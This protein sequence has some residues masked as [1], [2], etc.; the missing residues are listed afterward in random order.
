MSMKCLFQLPLFCADS[1]GYVQM[2]PDPSCTA[3]K[4]YQSSYLARRDFIIGIHK[5]R[6]TF[7][8]YVAGDIFCFLAIVL[9]RFI[10]TRKDGWTFNGRPTEHPEAPMRVRMTRFFTEN[11]D[12]NSFFGIHKALSL[13]F[14]KIG[15]EIDQPTFIQRYLYYLMPLDP[16]N[17]KKIDFEVKPGADYY[18]FT[19]IFEIIAAVY[20]IFFWGN[21]VSSSAD[22]EAAFANSRFPWKMVAF[23]CLEILIMVVERIIY[24]FRSVLAKSMLQFFTLLY[25]NYFIFVYC[26]SKSSDGGFKTNASL[27]VFFL[28]KLCYFIP[29]S[30][31]I[32]YGYPSAVIRHNFFTKKTSGLRPKFFEQFLSIPFIFEL[33]TVLSWMCMDTSLDFKETFVF[34]DIYSKVFLIKCDLDEDQEGYRG[35][36]KDVKG[37]LI[38]GSI[39]TIVCLLLLLGPLIIYSDANP[40][41]ESNLV[42]GA[43]ISIQMTSSTGTFL[44]FS[45]T[46]LASLEKLPTGTYS[47]MKSGGY[48]TSDESN[49]DCQE[50]I[51]NTFSDQQ[52]IIT[53]PGFSLFLEGLADDTDS[54]VDVTYSFTRPYPSGY[55]T[56]SSSN[57]VTL[58]VSQQLAFYNAISS[59]GSGDSNTSVEI[60]GLLPRRLQLPGTDS[61]SQLDSSDDQNSNV[62]Y[63]TYNYK[64]GTR[65]WSLAEDDSGSG[66]TFYTYSDPVFENS[67]LNSVTSSSSSSGYGIVTIYASVVVTIGNFL[68]AATS[69]Q[70]YTLIYDKMLNVDDLLMLCEG[71]Y[72]ARM[73]GDHKREETLYRILVRIFRSPEMMLKMSTRKDKGTDS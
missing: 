17:K 64:N 56:I 34:E 49:D 45:S 27:I 36:K 68:R 51:F 35:E 48:L 71:V 3:N 8:E 18:T 69:G 1:D 63:L 39:F 10:L 61:L 40:S 65:Y 42:T 58:T 21:L 50:I 26:P 57:S 12:P 30:L 5:A 14:S 73:L 25:F 46:S 55:T 24:L 53:D 2:H 59:S 28:I 52:W 4:S 60:D 23:F 9:H 72:I 33:R 54:T 31:Q 22:V 67:A 47:A 13:L 43:E 37:K 29:S 11:R 41:T 6:T 38:T 70:M 32:K 19:F 16:I 44:I 62:F 66:V 7:A 20:S 15:F